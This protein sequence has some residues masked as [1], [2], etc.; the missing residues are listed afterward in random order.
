MNEQNYQIINKLQNCL[1]S[2]QI[3]YNWQLA[4]ILAANLYPTVHI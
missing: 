2:K 3:S 4:H 1:Q